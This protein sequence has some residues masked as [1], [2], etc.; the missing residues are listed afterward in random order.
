MGL[1]V[2]QPPI[3]VY[4][5]IAERILEQIESGKLA[6]GDR[7]PPER[8]LSQEF[9][10]NRK[11]V[12]QALQVLQLQGLLTRCQGAGT[13]VAEPKIE[14][15][16]TR[17]FPFTKKM[18]SRGYMPGGQVIMFQQQLAGETVSRQLRL[19]ISTPVYTCHRLR[20]VNREPVMLEKF[21]LPAIR[22]PGFEKHTLSTRSLFEIMETEYG[23]VI[24]QAQQS[25]EAVEATSYEA[26]LLG[27]E[28]GASLM[29]ERRLSFDQNNRPVEYA[30]DLYRGDRFRFVTEVASLKL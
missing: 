22:F 11:T 29:L 30:K 26:G 9:S 13:Y 14:R 23:V 8:K 12:R 27:I 3:P 6:P 21:I 1:S 20:F 18:L 5:Q 10:V 16:A 15:E 4:L 17:L 7:L 2:N 24:S 19:P 28:P 25:L